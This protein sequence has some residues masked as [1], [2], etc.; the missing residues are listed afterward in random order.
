MKILFVCSD[1]N[2]SG[3]ALAMIELSE[4]V[5]QLGEEVLLLYPGYG[6]AVEEARK[7][8]LPL[9]VIRSYEWL[10]PL[11]RKESLYEKTRWFLKHIWNRI[12]IR[13]ICKLIRN[14]R[15]DIV[16]NNTLW[17]YVGPAAA[18]RTHTP[19]VWHMRELLEQQRK[20]LR[21]KEY[22]ERLIGGADALIAISGLVAR[23]YEGRFPGGKI[24]LV[25]DGVDVR[26]MYRKDHR[27]F[28]ASKTSLL[29][30]GGVREHKRQMDVVQAVETLVHK[31]IDVGLTIV[32][33]DDTPY[34]ENIKDYILKKDLGN[35]VVFR[36]ETS[37]VASCLAQSDIS[38]TSSQFE[39]FGRATAEA[40]LAGC[41]AVVSNSGANQEIVTDGETGYVYELGDPAALAVAIKRILADK[42]KAAECATA[43]RES[44]ARRF[45]NMENAHRVVELYKTVLANRRRGGP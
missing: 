36:G 14:E 26:K 7:R 30:V 15:I 22:G 45:D 33:D 39:G 1:F 18:R 9:A 3:A 25:Y 41:V 21:W 40:M 37:D 34:A 23:N 16:H 11:D 10:K 32:G 13:R 42:K 5:R 19:Y 17:G 24:F 44:V 27:L 4:K 31:G 38:V 35:H 2:R 28:R 29:V 20:K 8:G 6:D 43:G 12:A